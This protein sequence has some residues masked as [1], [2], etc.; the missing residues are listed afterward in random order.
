MFDTM[1]KLV[2]MLKC[3]KKIWHDN[4]ITQVNISQISQGF[5]VLKAKR[6]LITGGSTGI[7]LAIAKKCLSKELVY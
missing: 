6:V 5:K 3:L 4:G 1:L 7:G 2:Q